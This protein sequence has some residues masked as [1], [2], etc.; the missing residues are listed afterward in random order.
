MAVSSILKETLVPRTLKYFSQWIIT[1]LSPSRMKERS[2]LR[3]PFSRM[4][5]K[6]VTSLRGIDF[7]KKALGLIMILQV[8]NLWTPLDYSDSDCKVS[9]S[10]FYSRRGMLLFKGTNGD[11]CGWGDNIKD[12]GWWLSGFCIEGFL[13]FIELCL[14]SL[15]W[16]EEIPP[17]G[18]AIRSLSTPSCVLYLSLGLPGSVY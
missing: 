12:N 1:S 9:V 10:V 8:L 14:R 16:V 3:I 4:T 7:S 17:L 11:I 2:L 15:G 18:A 6:R 5:R 13:L